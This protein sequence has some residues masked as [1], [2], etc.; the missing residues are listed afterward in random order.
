MPPPPCE[1]GFTP[2]A[3]GNCV[4]MR[5]GGLGLPPVPPQA[6]YSIP[7]NV[8]KLDDGTCPLGYHSNSDADQ[9]CEIDSQPKLD[10]GRCP[11]GTVLTTDEKCVTLPVLPGSTTGEGGGFIQMLPTKPG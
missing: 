8:A 11:F 1:N 7:S 4:D 3:N 2:D 5:G 10:D 9:Q 6:H